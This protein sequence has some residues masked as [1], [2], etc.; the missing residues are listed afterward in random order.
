ME[1]KEVSTEEVCHRLIVREVLNKKDLGP[2]ESRLFQCGWVGMLFGWKAWQNS[3]GEVGYYLKLLRGFFQWE[4]KVI[5]DLSRENEA[6]K[7]WDEPWWTCPVRNG[8]A[9][10]QRLPE[11]ESSLHSCVVGHFKHYFDTFWM[12]HG[13]LWGQTFRLPLLLLFQRLKLKKNI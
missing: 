1:K 12:V 4:D 9:H 7:F 8:G 3:A 10:R 13:W 6:V 11:E 2:A 5:D